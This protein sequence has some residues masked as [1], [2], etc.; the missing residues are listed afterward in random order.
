M[1]LTDLEWQEA[2]GF[3]TFT[4]GRSDGDTY[5]RSGIRV[6]LRIGEELVSA[7]VESLNGSNF[8][9]DVPAESIVRVLMTEN[10]FE[11]GKTYFFF[12][13]SIEMGSFQVR[14]C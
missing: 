5:Y 12:D 2:I 1:P 8:Q 6:P 11:L 10:F 13:P 3:V 7:T 9:I 4:K 14:D